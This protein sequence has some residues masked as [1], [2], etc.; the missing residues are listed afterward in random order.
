MMFALFQEV[1]ETHFAAMHKTR[2]T[3]KGQG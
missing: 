3:M 1:E 2:L